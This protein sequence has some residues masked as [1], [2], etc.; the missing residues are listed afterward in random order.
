MDTHGTDEIGS[1]R[2]LTVHLDDR[3][4]DVAQILA[5]RRIAAAVV[6]G[7]GGGIVGIVSEGDI[8]KGVG[9][10]GGRL[11]RVR[12]RHLMTKRILAC[13]P[14]DSVVELLHVMES[15][16]I[17]HMPVVDDGVLVGMVSLSDVLFRM[18]A[19]QE[20]SDQRLCDRLGFRK[21]M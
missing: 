3:I 12:V 9:A 15:N 1:R 13:S 14:S 7:D 20:I 21:I 4:V 19:S 5:E 10:R 18:L 16:G 2:V 11:T 17:G 8:S 6:T